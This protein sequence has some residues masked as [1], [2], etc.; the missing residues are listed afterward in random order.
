MGKK[1][2]LSPRKIGQIK[3][4]LENSTLNQKE[5][6]KKLNVSAATITVTK[7]EWTMW[8]WEENDASDGQMAD[9]AESETQASLIPT[10]ETRTTAARGES[11]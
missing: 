8:S 10:A 4:L 6:A 1:S 2:D 5:I 7:T 11:G 9:K 3:V